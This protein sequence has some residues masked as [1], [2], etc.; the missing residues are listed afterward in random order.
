[1]HAG[2]QDDSLE[3]RPLISAKPPRTLSHF[4][5]QKV[6]ELFSFVQRA[7]Q[8]LTDFSSSSLPDGEEMLKG[9][10]PRH[11]PPAVGHLHKRSSS[12][13]G[14]HLVPKAGRSCPVQL[15]CF[16][17]S[18]TPKGSNRFNASLRNCRYGKLMNG[19]ATVCGP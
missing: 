13:L 8:Q 7:G 1:M 10:C 6:A 2:C 17:I 18:S 15:V 9:R 12:E 11:A 16:T 19:Y 4:P 3:A 5:P 14:G